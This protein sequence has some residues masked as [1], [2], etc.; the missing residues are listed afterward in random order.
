MH[1]RHTKFTKRVNRA[2]A[3]IES[4]GV[5]ATY[6]IHDRFLSNR[7]ARKRFAAAPPVL[8]ETQ[9]KVLDELRTEG[10][11]VVKFTDLFTD[12]AVWDRLAA[13]GD[14]FVA[15]TEAGLAR[16]AAGENGNLRR[17]TKSFLVRRN[18]WGAELE[19][20]DVW[21]QT[22]LDPRVLDIA[23]TYLGL[24][25]KLEY[26]D[27]WHTP[28]TDAPERVSSQR[29]HRDFNDRLLLKAFIYLNDV[30]E[31]AGPFEYVPRSFPGGEFDDFAPW[32]PGYHGY[33]SDEAFEKRMATAHVET[34]TA[35]RGTLILCN[36]AGFHRGGYAT[37][38]AR[39]LATWTYCSPAALRA[40]SD[41]NYTLPRDA[42]VANGRADAAFAVA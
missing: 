8:D 40:L 14:R 21:L 31:D 38:N 7:D 19:P 37:G 5:R 23:N 22:A 20:D 13:E 2:A 16:E 11:C 4:R 42:A 41:R 33:P 27:L 18:A 9:R 39:T 29:W 3:G 6:D 26:V 15:E 12:T 25:S 1:R 36:T 30:E 10:F 17:S 34:F 35:P 32:W 28:A 24:W